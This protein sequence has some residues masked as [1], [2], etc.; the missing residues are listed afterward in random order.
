M[1]PRARGAM[2]ITAPT[3]AERVFDLAVRVARAEVR[4]TYI[5]ATIAPWIRIRANAET[6]DV[7]MACG[8]KAKRIRP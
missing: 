6:E 2:L 1:K 3:H 7:Y 8:L 4:K 5:R